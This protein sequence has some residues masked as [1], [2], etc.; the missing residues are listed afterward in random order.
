MAFHDVQLPVEVERGAQG[1]PRFKTTIFPLSSGLEKRNIDWEQTR[2]FW[3][4]GYGIQTKED[5]D[6]VKAF[7]YARLGRAHSF[8]FKDW[9]DF[10]IERQTVMTTGGGISTVQLFK[11]YVSDIFAY[12]RNITKPLSTGVLAWVNT[13]PQTVVY[14]TTPTG[15]QVN[16]NTLTGLVT[17]G[18]THSATTGQIV[19]IE[20][21]FDV[22]VRFDTDAFDVNMV[23]FD[24]GA[25]PQLAIVEVKGE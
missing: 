9:S 13:V 17:I 20:S 23:T 22:A 6:I 11:Q 8:R 1:G 21:E 4:V 18:S 15:S 10:F 12:N 14:D 24:A 5:F 7:F 16:I 2:G 19:A 3:D 25:I